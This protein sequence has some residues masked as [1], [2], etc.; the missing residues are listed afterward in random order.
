MRV[1]SYKETLTTVSLLSLTLSS[2]NALAGDNANLTIKGKYLPT[3]CHV[4]FDN[5]VIDL[6]NVFTEAHET[7]ISG[8]TFLGRKL[9]KD[10]AVYPNEKKATLTITCNSLASAGFKVTDNYKSFAP[11]NLIGTD[12][13]GQDL[14][15]SFGFKPLSGLNSGAKI[16]GYF[17]EFKNATS[18]DDSRTYTSGIT[19]SDAKTSTLDWIKR[20]LIGSSDLSK[21]WTYTS[22]SGTPG[23]T[24][25]AK[26]F[27]VDVIPKPYFYYDETQRDFTDEITFEGSSTFTIFYI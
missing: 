26:T 3:T 23:L 19:L 16:G 13:A 5:P 27:T 7:K 8:S 6:G 4:S 12:I 14:S 2:F 22:K 17:F 25:K 21:Y 1:N 24:D 11:W 9:N 10:V 18:A 15:N 20:R